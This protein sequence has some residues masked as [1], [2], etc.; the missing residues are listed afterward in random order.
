M[1]PVLD[2]LSTLEDFEDV[3]IEDIRSLPLQ[4]AR[5]KWFDGGKGF[6]FANIFG[7]DED[8]FVHIEVLRRSVLSNLQAGEAIA[9]R[10]VEGKRGRMA[11][12]VCPWEMGSSK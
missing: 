3:D 5:V 8:I 12:D 1:N 11:A 2:S 4:A 6:G 7:N 9:L 10:V